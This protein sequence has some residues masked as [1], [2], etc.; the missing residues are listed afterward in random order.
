MRPITIC[1]LSVP[2]GS[3]IIT[4]HQRHADLSQKLTLQCRLL[5]SDWRIR[6]YRYGIQRRSC[7]D[8]STAQ[9][10]SFVSSQ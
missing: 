5:G 2:E 9:M 3:I 4:V 1:V 8:C 10:Q 6:V 7:V